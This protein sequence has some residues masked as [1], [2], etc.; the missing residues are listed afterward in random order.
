MAKSIDKLINAGY[1]MAWKAEN[2]S[3]RRCYQDWPDLGRLANVNESY[4]LQFDTD[5]L[6]GREVY[7]PDSSDFMM[8]SITFSPGGSLV[9]HNGENEL[10][11]TVEQIFETKR[12]YEILKNVKAEKRNT[13]NRYKYGKYG[14]IYISAARGEGVHPIGTEYIGATLVNKTTTD[15]RK[16]PF[17][18]SDIYGEGD[19][20]RLAMRDDD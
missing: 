8:N 5:T 10:S 18:S 6:D 11:F 2:N 20:I 1:K 16:I 14:N 17:D 3:Y 4:K 19:L 15:A 13:G 12:I 9:F 7:V